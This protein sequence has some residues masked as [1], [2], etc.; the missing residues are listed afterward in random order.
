M[1]RGGWM[2]ASV[3]FGGGLV[4]AGG[5]ASLD[6]YNKLDAAH[7]RVQAQKQHLTQELYDA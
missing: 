3:V 5:C 2:M 7:R 4:L 1:W 6:D